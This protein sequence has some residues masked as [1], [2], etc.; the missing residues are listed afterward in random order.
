CA[1]S[2]VRWY[3]RPVD[4][5]AGKLGKHASHPPGLDNFNHILPVGRRNQKP[6]PSVPSQRAHHLAAARKAVPG[7]SERSAIG[8]EAV[9]VLVVE[10]DE[11]VRD[12][13]QAALA[14][15]G[16]EA[17]AAGDGPGALRVLEAHGDI[18]LLLTDVGLPGGMSGTALAAEARRRKPG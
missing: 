18:R 4:G 9:K 15:L 11:M 7:M 10:D 5:T 2:F 8:A 14:A 3:I 16:Y 17:L 13:A 12:Y 1:G 6:R